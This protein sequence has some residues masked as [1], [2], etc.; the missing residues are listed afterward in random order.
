M[1]ALLATTPPSGSFPGGHH[2]C[3]INRIQDLKKFTVF[4]GTIHRMAYTG[5]N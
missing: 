3:K 2:N 5:R 1:E 4:G